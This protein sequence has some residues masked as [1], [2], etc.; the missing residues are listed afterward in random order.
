MLCIAGEAYPWIAW[1]SNFCI[2][3]EFKLSLHWGKDQVEYSWKERVVRVAHH[4]EVQGLRQCLDTIIPS[5]GYHYMYNYKGVRDGCMWLF[6]PRD[7]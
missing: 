3:E 5:R 1:K 7:I 2:T 4:Q 6:M